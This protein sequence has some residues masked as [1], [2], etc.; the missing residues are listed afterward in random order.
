VSDQPT[1]SGLYVSGAL[2]GA[3]LAFILFN[4]TAAPK[5]D[6][7]SESF[8]VDTITQTQFNEIMKGE[9]DAKPVK[10]PPPDPPT[11][12]TAAAETP[13]PPTPPAPPPEL[14]TADEPPPPEPPKAAPPPPPKP[15]PPSPAPPPKLTA[16][17]APA[18]PVRPKEP[19]PEK[20]EKA[21]KTEKFKPD[22]LAK[23]LEK[24]KP[25]DP[26]KPQ[27]PYDPNAIAKLIGQ[28][29][30]TNDPATPGVAPAQ[31][32]PNQHAQ[33]MSPS[34]SAGLD[35]WLTEAYLNCWTPPPTMPEGDRYVAEIRVAFNAD[36]TLSGQ[37]SL[38]N[39]PTDPAWRAH[40][41]SALRAVLKCNPLHI[42]AQYLPYFEQWRTKTVHFDPESAL[43]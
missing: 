17:D 34:Q 8:P 5:F 6:D 36:G 29:K 11:R 27:K 16:D 33:R 9:R 41:E 3:L 35:A 15:A 13:A 7:A 20:S 26:S 1:K 42:P 31:G 28:T 32:L 40:A 10:D 30:S 23:L 19:T 22:Q 4:F 2:H 18:P 12:Q 24:V 38:V 21:E 43:G 14:K 25:D 39:P 37:P